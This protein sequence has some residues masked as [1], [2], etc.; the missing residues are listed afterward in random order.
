MLVPERFEPLTLPDAATLAG[1]MAPSVSVIAGVVVGLATE[2]ETPFAVATETVDTVPNVPP[3]T[4]RLPLASNEAA[5][6]APNV[7]PK[8]KGICAVATTG[9]PA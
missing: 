4:V 3:G 1:V 8:G 7:A 2:P 9:R 6:P 5:P